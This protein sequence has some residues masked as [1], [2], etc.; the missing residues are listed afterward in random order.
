[1][2]SPTTKFFTRRHIAWLLVST[3]LLCGVCRAQDAA[4]S[5]LED[6]KLYFT[7]PLRWDQQDWFTFGGA[8]AATAIS[9]RYDSDVRTHFLKDNPGLAFNTDTYDV[10]DAIPAVIALA[11]TL[12]FAAITND[13]DGKQETWSMVEAAGLSMTTAFALK[14]VAGRE[15]PSET[16]D[17]TQWREGG[18]SFPS[19]HATGAFAIGTVLAESGSDNFRWLRRALGYGVGAYTSYERLKHNQ[20]WLSDTVAGAAL[21]WSSARFVLNRGVAKQHNVQLF[22][23]P[24]DGGAMVSISYD[25]H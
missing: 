7:A 6:I 8:I 3:V 12:T 13:K 24:T 16:A 17:H 4:D 23:L 19:M 10:Q 25:L 14:F 15:R 5:T 18:D 9:Y 21:G 1:M 11:G 2:K 20:H 22:V